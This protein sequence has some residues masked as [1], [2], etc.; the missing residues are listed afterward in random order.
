MPRIGTVVHGTL[1][2][3]DLLEALGI[4]LFNCVL[5]SRSQSGELSQ[6]HLSLVREAAM[7]NPDD[8]DADEL[9]Q[10]LCDALD[11]YAPPYCRF[12]AHEGDGSDFG[13]WP[14]MES[15]E[16]LPRV[17]DPSEVPTGED[18]AY[19]NDHGNVTVYGVDGS[20]LLELV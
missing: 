15:I 14:V 19:V 18:C 11:E 2:T 16:E 8:E 3:G 5:H 17:S 1:R 12:G 4:E 10:N 20:V 7:A 6:K 13:F 9:V